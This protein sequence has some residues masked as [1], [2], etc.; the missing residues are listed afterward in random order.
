[1]NKP[2]HPAPSRENQLQG[3]S[4]TCLA[5]GGSCHLLGSLMLSRFYLF[6]GGHC[7]PSSEN[8]WDDI[9]F[10]WTTFST[11]WSLHCSPPTPESLHHK[12]SHGTAPN[13]VMLN[14]NVLW[15]G[16]NPQPLLPL[17][18][19]ITAPLTSWL[20]I[21][22]LYQPLLLI[23]PARSPFSISS[24]SLT[25]IALLSFP[26]TLLAEPRPKLIHYSPS[27]YFYLGYWGLWGKKITQLQTQGTL[28]S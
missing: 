23:P 26:G 3:A 19:D 27:L 1:M 21:F 2:L 14:P 7:S 12:P 20:F 4:A 10:P 24:N 17:S 22:S 16:H 6:H 5:P 11:A 25:S 13:S 9:T 28:Q 8:I 18:C 15:A